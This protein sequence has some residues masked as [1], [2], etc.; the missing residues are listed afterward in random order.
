MA[1]R[2]GEQLV[3]DGVISDGQLQQGLQMQAQLGGRLGTNLIEI[4]ALGEDR[5]LDALGKQRASRT[6]GRR[7]LEGVSSSVI[8]LLPPKMAKR[9]QLVPYELQGKTLLIAS[10]DVV[11]AITEDEIRMLT[12]HMVRTALA[13][14]FRVKVAL[15]RY[16]RV[17]S[18]VRFGSLVKRLESGALIAAPRPKEPPP[19]QPDG[20][21]STAPPPRFAPSTPRPKI[22]TLPPAQ[23]EEP[24][25]HGEAAPAAGHAPPPRFARS[26]P[27]P[28]IPP[29]PQA[30]KEGPSSPPPPR[31]GDGRPLR[32]LEPVSAI[33]PLP[34]LDEQGRP[35]LPT[36]QPKR[37]D[38]PLFIELDDDDAELLRSMR[39][40]AD[41]VESKSTVEESDA[42]TLEAGDP[43]ATPAV[44]SKAALATAPPPSAAEAQRRPFWERP[45]EDA[46]TAPVEAQE[47][48]PT[49][50]DPTPIPAAPPAES[51]QADAA[52]WLAS[53]GADQAYLEDAF[54]I[55][56]LDDPELD[57]EER[58]DLAS[59]LLQAV[60]IRDE[61]AD[62]LLD[63]AAPYFERRL[64]LF[65]RQ[66]R[67]LGWRG[68]GGGVVDGAVRAVEIG[69]G[70]PSV[71]LSLTEA[72]SFWMAS[73]PPLEPNQRLVAGLGG[74]SPKDCVVLPV[75]VRSKVVCYFYGDNRQ[76]GVSGTPLAA[77]RRLMAKA[78][79]A[80][81]VYILKNKMRLL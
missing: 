7:Q 74:A 53:E 10:A 15:Q 37:P 62:V 80:F 75:M 49:P 14:E 42:R 72:S 8:R 22:P 18:G 52:P 45:A 44:P 23:A 24:T 58:L 54:E 59:D 57:L 40:S 77:M 21:T 63:F 41:I 4:G 35:K 66:E 81:E 65:R 73:L 36:I 51:M 61:I 67:I 64:L 1:R 11:D 68:D 46:A 13:L 71:F 30:M 32:S 33:I 29:L 78:G 56:R 38:K 17:P 16:Y 3:A 70:E 20:E 27:A 9:Y 47:T 79:M 34:E 69:L 31:T 25:L 26:T 12:G 39:D 48:D 55:P 60:E 5:L 50:P 43:G 6:A 28:P 2:L 19:P 76:S